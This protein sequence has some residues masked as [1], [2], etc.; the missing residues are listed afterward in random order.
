LSFSKCHA[1]LK[2]QV[3]PHTPHIFDGEEFNRAARFWTNGYDI[4]TPHR[5]YI[6][7]N[8]HESQSNPVIHTWNRSF[9][10]KEKKQ[11][12]YRLKTMIGIPGG[13]KDVVKATE[14]KRSKYGLGDRRSL[15]QLITFTGF[16]LPHGKISIN[17]ENHCGNLRWVPF[18]E[19]Q[20]GV[21]YIPKFDSNENPTDEPKEGS[22]WYAGTSSNGKKSNEEQMK[23]L[24]PTPK[25]VDVESIH[26][27]KDPEAINLDAKSKAEVHRDFEPLTTGKEKI[28]PDPLKYNDNK[29][30]SV[31]EVVKNEAEPVYD[32]VEPR[33][34]SKEEANT[35]PDP[36]A[37]FSDN[38]DGSIGETMENKVK[39]SVNIKPE[40]LP[41]KISSKIADSVN[42]GKK[43]SIYKLTRNNLR[44][45]KGLI[46]NLRVEHG[47][48]HLPFHVRAGV[49]LLCVFL[50]ATLIFN[51]LHGK[52][53]K[54][55]KY[56]R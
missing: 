52:S 1:E 3:D 31:D 21:N 26:D 43:K 36:Y 46:E 7:H 34:D 10:A 38:G 35:I 40:R 44:A 17:G 23:R 12:D 29:V 28:I 45:D 42:L 37:K 32:N 18:T 50:F 19:H 16:D 15:N 55:K 53:N 5:S 39:D 22:V 41:E 8:Y 27:N 30:G 4:Y 33:V 20:N 48:S 54:G 47:F 2:A 24:A 56:K 11:S 14:M 6:Y 25:P 51:V 13:E 49:I 9:D